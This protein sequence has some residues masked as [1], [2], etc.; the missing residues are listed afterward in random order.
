[1]VLIQYAAEI[2]VRAERRC[3]E[4]LRVT[5][6][7]GQRAMPG[8]PAKTSD[9]TTFSTL[10][11]MG[12]T[13]DESSRYQRLPAMSA[14]R[15]NEWFSVR[16]KERQLEALKAGNRTKHGKGSVQ[17][18]FPEPSDGQARDLAAK[19][20]GVSGRFVDNAAA[21]VRLD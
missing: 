4:L 3:G 9:D 20:V 7:N 18:T 12:L 1:M 5:A 10:A 21:M 2:K 19:A 6:E 14:L 11:D 8:R 16:A 13:R 17:E 15:L